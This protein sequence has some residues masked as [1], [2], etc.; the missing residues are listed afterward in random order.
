[1]S[2]TEQRLQ[3][4]NVHNASVLCN[5]AM[6]VGPTTSAPLAIYAAITHPPSTTTTQVAGQ[7]IIIE[8][9]SFRP[10]SVRGPLT[11]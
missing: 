1:M 8:G 5:V 10:R 9:K 4:A 7:R 3:N 6:F 2:V 11:L